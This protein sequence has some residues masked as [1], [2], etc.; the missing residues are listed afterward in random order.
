MMLTTIIYIRPSTEVEFFQPN[1]PVW[2][3]PTLLAYYQ[4]IQDSGILVSDI[5]TYSED[6]LT[7]TKVMTWKSIE[8][9]AEYVYEFTNLFPNYSSDR[10]AYHLMTG[11]HCKVKTEYEGAT[12]TETSI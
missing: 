9:W 4:K 10:T 6:N 1:S 8:D 7:M 12:I 3:D 11:S 5:I 2:Q